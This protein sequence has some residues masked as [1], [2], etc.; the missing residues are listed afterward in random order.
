[1]SIDTPLYPRP[2]GADRHVPGAHVMVG[3]RVFLDGGDPDGYLVT[4]TWPSSRSARHV[5]FDHPVEHSTVLNNV[6]PV[7]IA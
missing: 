5:Q 3:D 2:A 4:G 1:M 6:E 7:W